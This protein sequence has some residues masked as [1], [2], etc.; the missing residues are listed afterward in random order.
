MR[1]S[2]DAQ[3]STFSRSSVPR[4]P[5]LVPTKKQVVV[6]PFEAV[7]RMAAPFLP[8]TPRGDVHRRQ[9]QLDE[10]LSFRAVRGNP[11]SPARAS[12][13]TV[14]GGAPH[15][16]DVGDLDS[17]RSIDGKS[18]SRKSSAISSTGRSCGGAVMNKSGNGYQ[19]LGAVKLEMTP[20]GG[21]QV[22]NRRQLS[23]SP[24]RTRGGDTSD[25]DC[26]PSSP[27]GGGRR[28]RSGSHGGR[29]RRISLSRSPCR[30]SKNYRGAV[31]SRGDSPCRPQRQSLSPLKIAD[32]A[33]ASTDAA[34]ATAMTDIR[35]V[36]VDGG[37]GRSRK[38]S[39]SARQAVVKGS[40]I[41]L[42]A[43]D[44]S[45][46]KP[47]DKPRGY[48]CADGSIV[49]LGRERMLRVQPEAVFS[50]EDHVSGGSGDGGKDSESGERRERA[51]Q[52][53]FSPGR[54]GIVTWVLRFEQVES[55]CVNVSAANGERAVGAVVVEVTAR[56]V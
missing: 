49:V 40:R 14:V 41:D 18:P 54:W 12:I 39:S 1:C 29:D 31:N 46:G 50:S 55:C 52:Q 17:L 42:R 32:V 34:L 33:A 26:S 3:Y 35:S 21:D 53:I 11:S 2:T 45:K 44:R 47:G 20:P 10:A 38:E 24:Q 28:G 4:A 9:V 16:G 23:C 6:R 51:A 19:R 7:A 25:K 56:Y 36:Q 15:G 22:H 8:I 13:S 48:H 30:N 5:L 37:G 43:L 27:V